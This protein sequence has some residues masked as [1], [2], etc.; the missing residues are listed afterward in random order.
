LASIGDGVRIGDGASIGDGANIQD[1][2]RPQIIYIIGSRHAVSYWGEDRIDIGC[3]HHSIA[4]WLEKYK[5]IGNRNGYD[6][7]QVAE[8]LGYVKLIAQIH[9][10]KNKKSGAQA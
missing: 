2:Q 8:Y 7:A 4:E 3:Q 1:N 10:N 9:I 6:T 5:E